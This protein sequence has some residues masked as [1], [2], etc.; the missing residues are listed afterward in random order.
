V[1]KH[2]RHDCPG[3]GK[4]GV[5]GLHWGQTQQCNSAGDESQGVDYLNTHCGLFAVFVLLLV[6]RTV[7]D[8][9][10]KS[11]CGENVKRFAVS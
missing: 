8:S 11:V 2:P 10:K 1:Q 3:Q 9:Q 5:R 7:E 4:Y 6:C